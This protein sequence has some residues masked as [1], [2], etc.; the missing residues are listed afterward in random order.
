M[1]K[2]IKS[3]YVP[4]IVIN[5]C[6][7]S[8]K[9][10]EL[11]EEEMYK[12]VFALVSSDSYNVFNEVVELNSNNENEGYIAISCGGTLAP[13]KSFQVTLKEST[14]HLDEYNKAMYDADVNRY[15]KVLSSNHYRI[16]DYVAKFEAGDRLAKIRVKL[17]PEGLSPDSIY[18]IPL[19]IDSYTGYEANPKK[20]DLLYRVVLKNK[21]ASQAS[22]TYYTMNGY[23]N[24]A[25]IANNKRVH[26]LSH[27]KIRMMAG[28]IAYQA[29]ETIIMDNSVVVTINEDNSVDISP[30]RNMQVRMLSS[31]DA[32]PNIYYEDQQGLRK[33]HVF[34]LNYEYYAQNRWNQIQEELRIEMQ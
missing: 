9:D 15:A 24:G 21:Y 34:L 19:K 30:Y 6:M 8:C 12:N 1:K 4:L 16:D 25:V 22:D 32:F 27:N 23:L 20:S 2:F 31:N 33:F 3:L 5:V 7:L 26:P 17:F 29:D 10:F 13:S 14:D 28:T 11:F 18:F